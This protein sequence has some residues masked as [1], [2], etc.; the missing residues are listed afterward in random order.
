MII[1]FIDGP[2][3]GYI[4]EVEAFMPLPDAVAIPSGNMRHWYR[5]VSGGKAVYLRSEK[6]DGDNANQSE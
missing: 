4:H 2:M 6:Y 1:E 3:K 5:R